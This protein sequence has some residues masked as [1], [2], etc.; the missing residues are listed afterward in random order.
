MSLFKVSAAIGIPLAVLAVVS[1]AQTAPKQDKKVELKN[2]QVLKTATPETI[3]PLMRGISDALGVKCDHCHVVGADN[4]GWEKDDKRAKKMA[5][6]MMQMT[7]DLNKNERSV[8]GKVTCYMCHR[9]KA[10][11]VGKPPVERKEGER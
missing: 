10:E 1:I 3:L 4:T 9:G 2:V 6:R 8:E 7:M 11:A 5:R